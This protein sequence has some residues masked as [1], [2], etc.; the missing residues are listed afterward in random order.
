MSDSKPKPRTSKRKDAFTLVEVMVAT[1]IFTVAG[2]G[3]LAGLLQARKMTEGSIYVA[4]ATT[5]AQGYIEQIKNMEFNLLDGSTIPELI[6]QGTPD[7]LLISPLVAD[8]ETGEP[9]SDINN[10][11]TIDINNTPENAVDDLAINFVVY[12]EDI[13]D[14][15]NGVGDARRIVLRWSY[16]DNTTGSNVAVG[17]TLYAIRSR[18]PTF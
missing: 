13:T 14:E 18:I 16:V 12:V 11:R 4:T 2:L 17:N 7:S 8:V 5:V 15:A 10:I 6:S 3:T 9:N 1:V